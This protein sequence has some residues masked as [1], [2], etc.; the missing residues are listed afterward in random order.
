M[1]VSPSEQMKLLATTLLLLIN[2]SV[3]EQVKSRDFGFAS[4][5]IHDSISVMEKAQLHLH[6]ITF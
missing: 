1:L 3:F 4:Y 6:S 2:V 5:N